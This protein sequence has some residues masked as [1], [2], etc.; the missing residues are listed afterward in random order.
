MQN[1]KIKGE[2]RVCRQCHLILIKCNPFVFNGYYHPEINK[3]GKRI[4]CK[5]AGNHILFNSNEL[6]FPIKK[7]KTKSF[8]RNNINH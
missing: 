3:F 4:K 7:F 2:E 8:K 6:D 5:N 1:T